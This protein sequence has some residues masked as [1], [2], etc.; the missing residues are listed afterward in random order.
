MEQRC[1]KCYEEMLQLLEK[2]TIYEDKEVV[3][4]RFYNGLNKESFEMLVDHEEIRCC[5]NLEDMVH[6]AIR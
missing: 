1:E 3:I 5:E 4:N 6:V 2:M